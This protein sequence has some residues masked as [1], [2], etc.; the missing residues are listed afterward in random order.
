MTNLKLSR[1]D[2]RY[3]HGQVSARLV[4][5]FNISKILLI[6]DAYAADP[7][8][9]ELYKTMAIGF[10][11]E[12][13]SISDAANAWKSG[14]FKSEPALMLLWGTV[15]DA[16]ASYKAGINYDFIS[17]ANI[18]GDGGRIKV[19]NSCYINADE[20]ELLKE[21]SSLGVDVYF[22]AMTDLPKTT[23]DEALKITGL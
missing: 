22:Q 6:S 4:R 23:L 21:L 20:A 1:V 16:C 15:S 19:N 9:S 14:E 5:E 17:L 13:R 7:F 2:N 12:V 8:M 18:P 3:I 10:T 11:V